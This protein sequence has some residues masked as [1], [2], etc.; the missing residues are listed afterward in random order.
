[1]KSRKKQLKKALNSAIRN[2]RKNNASI[3]LK[4]MGEMIGK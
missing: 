2:D 1:M 4:V 3:I